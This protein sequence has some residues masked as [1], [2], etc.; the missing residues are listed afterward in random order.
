MPN[1]ETRWWKY[2][3]RITHGERGVDV[4]HKAGFDQSALTRWKNGANADP[5]FVVQL[6]RAYHQNV[7]EALAESGLITDQEAALHEVRSGVG[8]ISTKELIEELAKRID[9]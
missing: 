7:L 4:A 8:D 2:V 3:Q 6:A 5:K 9:G 1:K